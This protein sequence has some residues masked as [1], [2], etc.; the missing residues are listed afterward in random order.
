MKKVSK[1]QWENYKNSPRGQK[2]I[3]EFARL[4][5]EN[6]PVE[7]ILALCQKYDSQCFVNQGPSNLVTIK[8]LLMF[9]NE[10]VVDVL[11]KEEHDNDINNAEFYEKIIDSLM[12]DDADS[13]PQSE[14]K[15]LLAENMFFIGI[16]RHYSCRIYG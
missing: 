6:I 4:Y 11:D 7:E 10:V 14:F 2:V 12:G 13:K 15:M 3:A 1:M 8:R 5:N 16:C 9:F